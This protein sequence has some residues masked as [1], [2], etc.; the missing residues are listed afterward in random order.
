MADDIRG[1]DPTIGR[2]IRAARVWRGLDQQVLAHR[3]GFTQGY[4]SKIERGLAPVDKRATVDAFARALDV[5]PGDLTG[6]DTF[7][8]PGT[9]DENAA[10]APLRLALAD[11]EFGEVLDGPVA[12]WPEIQQGVAAVNALRPLADYSKLAALLPKLVRGLHGSVSGTHRQDALTGL[13]DCYS[14]A[15]AAAKN[16]GDAGLAQIAARNLRDVTAHLDGLEWEGLAAWARVNAISSV[17]RERAYVVATRAANKLDEGL[18]KPEVAELYGMLHLSAAL[19]STV[20][21]DF[22]QA[23]T[24]LHEAECIAQRPGVAERNFSHQSFG[25]GNVAIWK[26]MIAVESGDGGKAAEIAARVDPTMLPASRS[27]LAA[28][29]IDIGR[30]MAMDR[31]DEAA[32][33][34]FRTARQ[35]APQRAHANPWVREAVTDMYERARRESV[36]KN[37]RGM[38]F[39]L[40]IGRTG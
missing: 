27:R 28:W 9:R 6:A 8:T 2:R 37:L 20:A 23:G 12:P 24:H 25:P 21:G 4:L 3:A 11:V 33:A 32:I 29:H 15:W 17:A 14:A 10:L 30:G 16:L 40:G 7:L 36:R 19:G 38:A 22:D 1:V 18:D 5:S 31:R 39:W 35:L 13:T 34:A 26:T